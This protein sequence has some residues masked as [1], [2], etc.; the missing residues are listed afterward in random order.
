MNFHLSSN[1]SDFKDI[2][3]NINDF[4]FI[5]EWCWK[6]IIKIKIDERYFH[7]GLITETMALSKGQCSID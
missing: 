2:L 1:R 7:G 4:Y 5:N 6:K 3:I